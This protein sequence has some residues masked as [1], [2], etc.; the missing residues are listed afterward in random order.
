MAVNARSGATTGWSLLGLPGPLFL[1]E[2][3]GTALLVAVGCSWVILDFGAG[4]PVVH[5]LPTLWER[6]ALTGMLF[7]T[8]GAAIAFSWIGKTSG[9]HIN[10][11]VSIAFWW[12][13]TI[14]G[15][16]VPGYVVAQLLGAAIGG[17]VLRLWGTMGASIAYGAT[18][19]GPQG[20]GAACLGEAATTFCLVGGIL[21]FLHHRRLRPV[22]PLMLPPLYAVMVALEAPISGT[23]TNPARTLGSAVAADVWTAYWVYWVGPLL[24]A[25][26]AVALARRTGIETEVAK[27]AHFHHDPHGI[28]RRP[29]VVEQ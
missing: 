28:L 25:A 29:V 5:W 17:L 7:G 16:Y 2:L 3:L 19:P 18:T 27:L 12:T 13:G 21:L 6:R 15:R 23:S 1:A 20:V 10:P 9:A 11:V 24:G 26:I 22:T 14:R 4:S 8:T